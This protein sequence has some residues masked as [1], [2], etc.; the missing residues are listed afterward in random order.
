MRILP[1]GFL[2]ISPVHA[3]D[4]GI[5]ICV[6]RNPLGTARTEGRL[7]VFAKPS[8]YIRPNPV[9]E[10]Q[11]GE[12]IE[13]PC[14]AYLESRN[15]Y[16]DLAYVWHHNGLRIDLTKMPQY[17][18]GVDGNLI[19]SNLTLAEIGEYECV[20]N[21]AVG[22]VTA[23]TRIQL[24]AQPGAPGAVLADD[25]TA[26]SARLHWSDGFDY[27]RHIVG[28]QIEGITNHNEK[29]EILLNSSFSHNQAVQVIESGRKTLRLQQILSPW[30]TYRFRVR[31]FND[32]GISEASE[33]SPSYNT[34]KAQPFKA[35]SN[36]NGG[37][38]NTGTLTI[39]WDPLPPKDWNAPDIWYRIYYK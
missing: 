30:S 18:M 26:T 12:S 5:Y 37:G 28:Y 23:N 20:V 11:V 7:K 2:Q 35:P 13:M 4:E 16:L 6:A 33:P 24:Y 8:I 19:I 25:I 34:D 14:S 36:V 15:T 22:T 27:G 17:S 38:G 31:A 39:T 32:I 29:W 1:N 3:M 10:R 9:Y 21:S